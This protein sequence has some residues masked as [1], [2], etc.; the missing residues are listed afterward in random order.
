MRAKWLR[1]VMN[2]WP[3]FRA[4]GIRITRMDEDYR[5]VEV[6]LRRKLFNRNYVGTHFGGSLFAMTDPFYMLMLIH[7]LGDH[8]L[9]WDRR[10]SIEFLR[11]GEG[12]V[13]AHFQLHQTRIDSIIEEAAGGQ[14]THH[15]FPI[16]VVGSDGKVV[17]KVVKTVYVR[18]KPRYRPD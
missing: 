10:A 15:D 2:L 14:A 1:L 5:Y 13:R 9:V 6:S 3:P 18:L 7:N 17:A 16:E 11:P 8:Y 4:A 12:T